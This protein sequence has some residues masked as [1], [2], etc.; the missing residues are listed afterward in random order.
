VAECVTEFVTA[1][2]LLQNVEVEWFWCIFSG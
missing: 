2:V 1:M